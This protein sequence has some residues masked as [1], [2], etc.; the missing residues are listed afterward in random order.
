LPFKRT[1]CAF[2]AA[3][4]LSTASAKAAE[5]VAVDQANPPFM[6]E[7]G[8]KLHG[9]YPALIRETFRRMGE[10]VQLSALPWRRALSEADAGACGIAAIY[11]TSERLVKFD[12][13][14]KLFDEVIEVYVAKGKGFALDGTKGLNGRLVG[15]LRGWSYGDE[16]DMAVKAGR[17][18]V[19][20]ASGDR[21]N[22]EKLAAGR[23]DAVLANRES[24]E[25]AI[26]A[27]GLNDKVETLTSP[28]ISTSA[29]LA[30]AK[31]AK[32]AAVIA[33]FNTALAAMH[34]DGSFERIIAA[35]AANTP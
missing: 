6:Y 34:A 23:L 16:F 18:K 33:R 1:F 13:S 10:D 26:A 2:L 29:Y 8:G 32:K 28:L 31:S 21:Q 19:E 27:D 5:I 22:F 15:V 7:S 4:L 24:A 20:E 9:I 11:K 12:F 35:S 14:D 3:L 25:I 30:F 17:I